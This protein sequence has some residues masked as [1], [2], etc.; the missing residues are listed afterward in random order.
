MSAQAYDPLAGQRTPEGPQFDVFLAGTVFLDIIFTG[1]PAMPAAG[2]EIWAEGMGSCPGGIA[3]LAIATSRLGLRTSLAAAFGDDDYGDF[4][5]RTLEEQESVDLTR[6]RRF[7]HWH[8]PVTVSMA[9]ERDRSMVTHGHPPPMPVPEMIGTPPRSRAVIVSLSPDEP[10]GGPGDSSWAE[11]AHQEG[12][13]IFA[14]VGWDPSGTWSRSLLD[15]LAICHAFMPNAT[16]AMAYT[17][18]DTPRDALYTIADKVPLAVVTDG[19]NGAMAIDSTTGE[20]AFVPAPRV[21]ALDPTGAG[22]VFGAGF[23]LGTLCEWP[24]DDRLAFAGVC[25][26]LAVQ[27]FGGSLAAPGWGDIADWWHEVRASAGHGGA[28]GSSLARRYAFLD[29][30][31]PT[32]PV[33]AVRRAAAT[34]ARYADVGMAPPASGKQPER[35]PARAEDDPP[36]EDPDTPRAPAQKE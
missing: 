26:A 22:D 36:P 7:E 2:T 20:E 15:Q 9:V 34:I 14:D 31:V 27:Q 10:L 25:A 17:G 5:W 6:S 24:L 12:A 28:Y 3:N 32:V 33:G 8:S 18:A 4:C 29:R 35:D 16:E 11:L 13:L 1:L 19:A 30:L 23:V 21:T